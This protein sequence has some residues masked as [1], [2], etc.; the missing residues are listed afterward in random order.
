VD[1]A[2]WLACTDPTAMLEFLRARGKLSER[3][4]RLFAV[5]CCRRVWCLLD[6][7]GTAAVAVAEQYADGA[8]SAEELRRTE[9]LAWWGA[10]G[11]V[12]CE[13]YI[14]TAGWA[15]YAAVVG[16]P[17]HAADLVAKS[18]G[19]EEKVVVQ[20][21][22]LRDLFGPLPFRPVAISPPVLHW[23][24]ATVVRL[25]QATYD[26][27]RLPAGTLE[28]DRLAV[29]ADALEEAGCTDPDIL[30]HLRHQGA[31]HVRGCFVLDQLLG[32]V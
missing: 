24:E 27:R 31:V 14:E 5:A 22:L 13:D 23:R 15:A 6:Q 12:Y 11:L 8:T 16:N 2:T 19:P 28:P 3:K 4:A 29:L 18:A 32:K 21:V 1:E 7:V 30:A 25:A 20:C 10:D 26:A 9:D 17:V